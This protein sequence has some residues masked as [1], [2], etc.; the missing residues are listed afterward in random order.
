MS[1]FVKMRDDFS[2]EEESSAVS[3]EDVGSQEAVTSDG[4]FANRV[5]RTIFNCPFSG[6]FLSREGF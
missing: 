5:L 4:L 3:T 2:V 6:G 1:L